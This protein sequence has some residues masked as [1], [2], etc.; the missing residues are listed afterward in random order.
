MRTH[1]RGLGVRLVAAVL[2]TVLLAGGAVGGVAVLQA[3]AAMRDDILSASL[4]AADMAAAQTAS[5]VADTRGAVVLLADRIDAQRAM[6]QHD[7]DYLDDVLEQWSPRN[8][9]NDGVFLFAEDGT[10][11]A[12]GVGKDGGGRT[13]VTER[14]WFKAVRI[15]HQSTFGEP[16]ASR[17]TGHPV[18]P[19]AAPVFDTNRTLRGIMVA[20]IS[21]SSL[22]VM[23]VNVRINDNSRAVLIDLDR[24]LTLAN[25]DGEHLL[26]PSVLA[27][28]ANAHLHDDRGVLETTL[29][30]GTPI[31]AAVAPVPGQR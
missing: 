18:V 1:S 20:P 10:L 3:R 31:L 28:E 17:G 24:D 19:L 12:D 2:G 27:A 23:M 29:Q 15:T 9:H 30:D 21:L 5:Y 8:P 25:A 4:A 13:T 11:L 16:T 7:N 22:S 6:E 26:E 14:D